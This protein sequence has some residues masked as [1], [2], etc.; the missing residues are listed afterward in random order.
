MDEDGDGVSESG[1]VC[2]LD[3]GSSKTPLSRGCP[4]SDADGYTDNEDA[5]PNN[6][7]QWNDTDD[8]GFGDNTAVSG[9]DACVNEYGR[10]NQSGRYGCPDADLDGWADVDDVFPDDNLQW[11]DSDGD[12]RGDNYVFEIVSVED[13]ANAGMFIMLREEQGDAFPNDLTQWSDR[14]GDGRGDNPTGNLPDAFPLRVS[15]QLDFDGDGYGD[16]ITLDIAGCD[17][18]DAPNDNTSH[19]MIIY[20]NLDNDTLRMGHQD[21]ETDN[22]YPDKF[23]CL[24]YEKDSSV[25]HTH[26]GYCDDGSAGGSGS[27]SITADD[28]APILAE[29]TPVSS[30]TNVTTPIFVFSSNESGQI[31]YGGSCTSSAR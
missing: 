25:F 31:N 29:V 26:I 9:G 3:A 2:P 17:D 1:D 13:E 24:V 28:Q 4:D 19:R 5:F 27:S 10:S 20:F 23:D 8:D 14:D 6:P 11:A 30:T 21:N 7:F 16:N 12:G 18:V 22:T 15:Q